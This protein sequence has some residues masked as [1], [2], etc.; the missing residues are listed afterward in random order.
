MISYYPLPAT[1]LIMLFSVIAFLPMYVCGFWS[2]ALLLDFSSRNRAKSFL[3][4]FMLVAFVLYCCHGLFFTRQYHLYTVADPIYNFASLA[5]YPMYYLYVRLLTVDEQLSPRQY[6]LLLPAL[7]SGLTIGLLNWLMTPAEEEA[8]VHLFGFREQWD[9]SPSGL[10]MWQIRVVLLSRILFCVQLIPI[11]WHT[12]KL[13]TRYQNR[14]ANFYSHSEGRSL[15][16]TRYIL[17]TFVVL[18]AISL[19]CSVIGRTY[20]VVHPQAVVIPSILFSAFLFGVGWL[21][22]HQNYTV[23]N[24]IKDE[25]LSESDEPNLHILPGSLPVLKNHL[26]ELM[27]QK[28]I[29]RKQDLRITDLAAM[30][31]TNRTYLSRLINSELSTSFADFV[32][33][34]RVEYAKTLLKNSRFANYGLLFVSEQAGFAS[35]N[36]F[37]RAFKK[38]EGVTPAKFRQLHLT[39]SESLQ[40]NS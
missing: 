16:W 27:E 31:N 23:V 40:K 20:F 12:F 1:A 2:L 13:I 6:L 25:T 11:V 10:V 36:S 9:T 34:Y 17:V 26:L 39:Q 22:S 14:I 5:V 7:F 35:L 15:Q 38:E 24:I 28:E 18:S 33:R 3:G 21:G 32:N 29:Y 19:I 37:L 4:V 30:L 8:Y